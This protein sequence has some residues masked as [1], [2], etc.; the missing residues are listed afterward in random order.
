MLVQNNFKSPFGVAFRGSFFLQMGCYEGLF[1]DSL[2]Y[3]GADRSK[4][5]RPPASSRSS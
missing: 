5:P 3:P 4:E 2:K 1:T